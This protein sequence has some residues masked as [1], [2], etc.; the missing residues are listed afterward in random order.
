M[1]DALLIGL[2]IA[3][4]T[5]SILPGALIYYTMRQKRRRTTQVFQLPRPTSWSGGTMVAYTPTS[6]V[7]SLKTRYYR[8]SSTP[9]NRS[10]STRPG[11]TLSNSNHTA[12]RPAL[13][14]F[15][16]YAASTHSCNTLASPA[17]VHMP[18]VVRPAVQ[19][20]TPQVIGPISRAATH[21]GDIQSRDRSATSASESSI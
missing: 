19:C 17:S 9:S 8:T 20:H 7:T 3:L 5:A 11:S 1:T 13:P 6:T 15:H 10:I 21:V 18:P 2:I 4:P 16:S 12:T 14:Q